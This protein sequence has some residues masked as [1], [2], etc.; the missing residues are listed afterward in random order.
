MKFC[1][2]LFS[3]TLLSIALLLFM[4]SKVETKEFLL[5][6]INGVSIDLDASI[7]VLEGDKQKVV[8]EGQKKLIDLLSKRIIDGHWNIAF[9]KN[10]IDYSP[11]KIKIYVQ[12]LKTVLQKGNGQFSIGKLEVMNYSV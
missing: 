6:D 4:D 5:E 2:V 7:E 1:L 10:I 12:D 3:S 8:I 9:T 11:L